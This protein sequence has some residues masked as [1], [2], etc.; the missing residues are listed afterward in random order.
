MF[1]NAIQDAGLK[2]FAKHRIEEGI[3][4]A[5]NYAR[6][7]KKHGSQ[8]RI[9]TVMKILESYGAHAKRAIPS[10]EKQSTISKM[11]NRISPKN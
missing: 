7:Q 8:K 4:L 10:L 3:E 11:K 6:T 9:V 5:A 2:L 1:A